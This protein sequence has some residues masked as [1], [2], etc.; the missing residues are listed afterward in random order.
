M[1]DKKELRKKIKQ[2][3][4]S[5]TEESRQAAASEAFAR[6][7]ATE[8]FKK[9]KKILLYYSLP[10]ELPTPDFIEKWAAKKQIYLPRVNGEELD[11]LRYNPAD[12]GLGSFQI[13]EPQGADIINQSELEL[14]VTPGVAF[15][16][17][18]NRLGRG[19][20]YYDRLLHSGSAVKVGIGYDFQLIDTDI[21][22]EPHDIPM[23]MVITDKR[24]VVRK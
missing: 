15:D 11:I 13:L 19:K 21:P 7:E 23:D 3:R 12:M 8:Q 14:I 16:N 24:V 18:C 4:L 20:G 1:L 5:V 10:D 17:N 6:L 22:V 9:A 2:L